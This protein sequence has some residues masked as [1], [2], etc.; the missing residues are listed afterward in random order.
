M[1]SSRRDIEDRATELLRKRAGETWGPEDE[2]E[3][4]RWME[5]STAN[6]VAFLRAEAAWE[7]MGRLKALG[8]G[9]PRRTV[10]T[11][12]ALDSIHLGSVSEI[13]AKPAPRSYR[14]V[15]GIAA[16]ILAGV[17]LALGSHSLWFTGDRYAT[18]V[19]GVA[20]M[21]LE[22]GSRITLNTDSKVRVIFNDRQRQI[23]LSQ[24]EAYFE[25]APDINRPFVVQAGDRRVVAVGTKFSVR[26]EGDVIQVVV[27]E[28]RVRVDETDRRDRTQEAA[29]SQRIAP[30]MLS[31]GGVVRA[32]NDEVVVQNHPLAEAEEILSWRSGY[33]I[34]RETRLDE[35]V[36]EFNRYNAR[37][38]VIRDA[39]VAAM[40]LTGKFR[41]TNSDAFVSLLRQT[42]DI[43]VER[44][45]AS[46][47]LVAPV[48]TPHE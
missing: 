19:G 31:A 22:D 16:S 36:A 30:I 35:A 44:T 7:E 39:S 38:I 15:V 4:T 33:V 14:A 41:A 2:A 42:Y 27:T 10:P 13:P 5:A 6:R 20:S 21:P 46:I 11:P 1:A 8:A 12:E 3:L 40:Q 34:F 48:V 23:D 18:P 28:G 32:R 29:A 47:V 43:E 26:R 25:V 17:G 37:Q 9:L 24:G 45:D